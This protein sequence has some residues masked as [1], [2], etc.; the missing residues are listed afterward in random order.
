MIRQNLE[1][2]Q[3]D[4]VD[5]TVDYLPDEEGPIEGTVITAK[6]QV[7]NRAG[8]N[9]LFFEIT[10]EDDIV[11][12]DEDRT[13]SVTLSDE[14]TALITL[15]VAEYDMYIRIDGRTTYLVGGKCLVTPR[16]TVDA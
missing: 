9:T 12:P 2:T 11:M 7:R 3:G 1:F 10:D 5:F 16:V 6:L 15:P 14:N 13:I 4:T 8:G